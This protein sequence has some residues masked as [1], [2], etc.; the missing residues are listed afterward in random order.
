[1]TDDMRHLKNEFVTS[2]SS[3][4][5]KDKRKSVSQDILGCVSMQRLTRY[6]NKYL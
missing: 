1:M 2:C 6:L 3:P 4:E 5:E